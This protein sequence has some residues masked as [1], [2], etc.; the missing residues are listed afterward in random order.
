M[1]FELFFDVVRFYKLKNIHAM[2]FTDEVKKILLV[3]CLG[4]QIFD[5]KFSRF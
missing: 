5:T 2:R 3:F 1:A 4:N